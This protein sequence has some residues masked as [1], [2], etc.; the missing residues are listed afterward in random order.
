MQRSD[1]MNLERRMLSAAPL[2]FAVAL[3]AFDAHGQALRDCGGRSEAPAEVARVIDGRS[4]LLTDGREVRLAAIE[5]PLTVPG[6]E[7]E[8]RV[9]AAVAARTALETLLLNREVHLFPLSSGPDRYGRLV[10]YA[11]VR[12][13]SG[14][15]LVQRELLA[16][17][18]AL[19][20]PT[21][22]AATCRIYLRNAERDARNGGLGLWGDPYHAVKAAADPADV[23][24]EQGR[25]A[26]VQGRV[27]SVRESGGMVYVN[28]GRR[29]SEQFTVTILKRN[30][31]IFAGAGLT[32]KALVGR[33][34]EVRGWVEERGGPAIELLRP[35]Q[36]EVVH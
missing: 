22:S 33:S 1:V 25:F 24:V 26:L 36:I 18:H 29:S 31:R 20:S 4:F 30:E 21:A 8:A 34:I 9:Q 14:E 12:T 27:M 13:P 10:A 28:F 11:F 32:P 3:T 19:V 6:D 15:A 7:D 17:G 2:A 5:T 23:L 16:A 35:E